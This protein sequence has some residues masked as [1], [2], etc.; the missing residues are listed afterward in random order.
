MGQNRQVRLVYV[1]IYVYVY[2]FVYICG[3]VY[4]Y[5]NVCSYVYIYVYSDLPELKDGGKHMMAEN[6]SGVKTP[7]R[8]YCVIFF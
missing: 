4:V 8:N 6:R 3:Y 2:V 5:F 1:R 7:L